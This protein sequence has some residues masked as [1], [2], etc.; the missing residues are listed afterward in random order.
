VKQKPGGLG[1]RRPTKRSKRLSKKFAEKVEESGERECSNK[2]LK[3]LGFDEARFAL[4]NWHKKRYCP[5]GF[6]VHLTW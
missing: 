1:T 6:L 4:I 3:V 2:P 5:K